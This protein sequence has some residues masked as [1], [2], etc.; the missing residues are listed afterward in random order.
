MLSNASS[1]SP[2][3]QRTAAPLR[4]RGAGSERNTPS[5]EETS[6]LDN[7]G[8]VGGGGSLSQ[9]FIAGYAGGGGGGGAADPG[10][11]LAA[12]A[13]G[14]PQAAAELEAAR[15]AAVAAEVNRV[16]APEEPGAPLTGR[17]LL[18]RSL[19]NVFAYL[20]AGVAM[21]TWLAGMSFLDAL[22]FCVGENREG[23]VGF[24]DGLGLC[25][26]RGRG[27]WGVH[28][29][30]SAAWFPVSLLFVCVRHVSANVAGGL[31]CVRHISPVATSLL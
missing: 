17:G 21:Y 3:H 14:P 2:S 9:P 11:D 28:L 24:F 6:L 22:Y 16:A 13:S 5:S 18:I 20:S 15:R 10:G 19:L 23:E 29:D 1:F 4:C 30:W 27:D 7:S 8:S 25:V 26:Y 31:R 12:A